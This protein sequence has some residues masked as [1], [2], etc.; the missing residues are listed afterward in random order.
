MNNRYNTPSFNSA[1]RTVEDTFKTK[2]KVPAKLISET[3][4]DGVVYKVYAPSPE[5]K[6]LKFNYG[7]MKSKNDMKFNFFNLRAG[8]STN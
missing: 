1:P 4:K 7:Y 6:S 3:V 5:R 2:K 8:W